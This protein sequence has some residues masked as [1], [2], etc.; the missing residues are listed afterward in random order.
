M[1]HVHRAERADGLI[2]ALGALLADP[3]PDPFATE[4]V[5]VPTRGMERWLTQRLSGR[6][7]AT[8][9]RSDG[10]SANIDFPSPPRLVARRCRSRFGNRAG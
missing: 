6:L 4:I 1:L 10:A 7:G 5:C 8:L 9:G 3:L 2:D